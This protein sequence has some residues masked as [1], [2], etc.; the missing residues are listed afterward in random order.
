MLILRIWMTCYSIFLMRN[1]CLQKSWETSNI[2]QS[3]RP[4]QSILPPLL[5]LHRIPTNI[6][7]CRNI[8]L[9]VTRQ[10][11]ILTT[12][13][14]H[15]FANV[16]YTCFLLSTSIMRLFPSNVHWYCY[17][18][19]PGLQWPMTIQFSTYNTSLASPYISRIKSRQFSQSNKNQPTSFDQ[20]KRRFGQSFYVKSYLTP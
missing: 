15:C 16:E 1:E 18:Y 3:M 9:K 2:H 8:L 5:S 11:S 6:R 17:P 14:K 4:T 20:P 13:C 12:S 19:F 10:I 7:N